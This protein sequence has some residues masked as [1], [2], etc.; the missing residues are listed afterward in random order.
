M[1]NTTHFDLSEFPG[2]PYA[3]ELK[4]GVSRLRFEP[5]LEAAYVEQHTLR[6]RRRVM[7]WFGTIL[8]IIGVH[9]AV[10]ILSGAATDAM[11]YVLVLLQPVATAVA[12]IYLI[13]RIR[14]PDAPQRYLPVAIWIVPLVA[15][16][17]GYFGGTAVIQ[18]SPERLVM[19]A[20]T[21]TGYFFFCGLL[22]RSALAASAVVIAAFA[23][24]MVSAGVAPFVGAKLLFVIVLTTFIVALASRDV[25]MAYRTNFL[26]DALIVQL[27]SADPLTGL[28]NRRAFDEHL[29]RMWRQAARDRRELAVLMIDIDHFKAY[30]DTCGHR[31]GDRTLQTVSQTIAQFAR[32]PMD[33][34]ARY[35]GEEFVVIFYDLAAHHVQDVAERMRRSV[36]ALQLEHPG[37]RSGAVGTISV[38]GAIVEPVLGRTPHGVVQ[39]ADQALYEA[40]HAGRN[41]VRIKG[42]SEYDGMTTGVFARI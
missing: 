23:L 36:E 6:V 14:R 11:G 4:R 22:F 34:I 20:L 9:V 25:E 28:K 5:A 8:A 7:I 24:A 2:S 42:A 33:L 41:T 15:A 37:M 30:N 38:G 16:L 1:T 29:L 3:A 26:E 21:L 13:Y 19:M 27:L 35:G 18:G 12:I 32:R 39:L 17:S 40:K 31:A 10:R